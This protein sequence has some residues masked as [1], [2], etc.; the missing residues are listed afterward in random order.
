MT[1]RCAC[2][3]TPP[4]SY[5]MASTSLAKFPPLEEDLKIDVAIVGGGIAG[6]SCAFMLAREGVKVAVLDA[7]KILHGT[8]GHTT[9][10]LTSQHELIY[11]RTKSLMGT[12]LAQQYASANQDA[13]HTVEKIVKE[14]NIECGLEHQSAFAYTQMQ[15]NVKK[16][17]DEVRAAADLGIKA[18]YVEDIPFSIPMKAAVRFDDQAQF[19]PLLYLQAL[20]KQ[21]VTLGGAIYEQTKIVALEEEDEAY[22]LV[23]EHGKNIT[24][25]KVV[26]ASHYPFYNK[27]GLYFARLSVERSYVLA[28]KAKEVYPGGMYINVEDPTRSLRS[29]HDGEGELILVGGE[30]HRTG[31]SDDTEHHYAALRVFADQ[32]FTVQSA[33]Y[34]W[35]TQD[36]ITLDNIPYVGQYKN[37]T[38]NLYVATGYG[39]WGMTNAT[40]SAV[41]LSDLIVRGE[42]P[43]ADVYNPSRATITASMKNL[44]VDTANVAAN[45]VKGKLAPVPDDVEIPNGEGKAVE[46]DGH[47]MG[48][49]RDDKG[50][51]HTVDTTCTHMGCEVNWNAAEH[52][53]DCPCHGS[54]FSIDGEVIEGP[55]LEP[56][57]AGKNVNT[58]KRLINEEY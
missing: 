36:C 46:I 6:I 43:Y 39:K 45:L 52:S 8:T 10:K 58:I 20:V 14:L 38:P 48:V 53:W 29:Y 33:P 18:T 24:A 50:E 40:A 15:E 4:Q 32:L 41:L 44:V 31:Q 19:H 7:G 55:A 27:A 54:R 1:H 25:G 51:L 42:S 37:D 47:R 3:D 5:W 35:S 11:S 21:I 34:H 49:F 9:A 12:E 30:S 17:E 56:L 16:I 26:I 22:R 13:I 57:N 2:L 23:T 28:V